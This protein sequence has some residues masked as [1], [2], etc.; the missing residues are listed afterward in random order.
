MILEI[1]RSTWQGS[2][3]LGIKYHETAT[4]QGDQHMQ[5]EL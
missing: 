2:Q 3:Y 5:L 1:Q 4:K